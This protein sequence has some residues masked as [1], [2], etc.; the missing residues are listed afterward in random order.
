MSD[1][2]TP[3]SE[4]KVNNQHLE[5]IRW[6]KPE[7]FH[8]TTYYL[9]EIFPINLNEIILTLE[10]VSLEHSKIE[11]TFKRLGFSPGKNPNMLWAY[12]NLNAAYQKLCNEIASSA[13]SSMPARYRPIP[14]VSLARLK[15][16]HRFYKPDF[17]L[18]LPKIIIVKKLHLWE[19]KTGGKHNSI[20]SFNLQNE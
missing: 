17:N 5:G 11:L 18:K 14:H 9:G 4:L 19:S 7:N 8:I 6:N 16:P 13:N 12:F 15:K 20:Q 10:S 3:F 2:I 1:F